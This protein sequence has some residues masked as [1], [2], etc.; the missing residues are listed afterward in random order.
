MQVYLAVTLEEKYRW[1]RSLGSALLGIL[2]GMLLSNTGV[3][4]DESATYRFLVGPG[5][6]VGIV[7]I[8]FSVDVRT[9]FSAGPKMAAAFGIAAIGT[10]VGAVTGGLLWSGLVGPETWKLTGQFTGTYTGGGVNFAALGEEF[11]TLP[12]MFTAGIAAK[13]N[14]E[15][16]PRGRVRFVVGVRL[17]CLQES[18]FGSRRE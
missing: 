6:S 10:A 11:D 18:G 13:N 16:S 8:L 15:V 2:M 14:T 1:A 3:L 5:V 4:P 9:V 12:E 17:V 7:L